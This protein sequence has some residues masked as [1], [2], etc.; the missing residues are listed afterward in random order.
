MILI[1]VS[2]FRAIARNLFSPAVFHTAR[3][4][5]GSLCSP[6]SPRGEGF[7]RRYSFSTYACIRSVVMGKKVF[8]YRSLYHSRLRDS[9]FPHMCRA[10]LRFPQLSFIPLEPYPARCARHFPHAGKAGDTRETCYPQTFG[11]R[12]H[13]YL[14]RSRHHNPE[15]RTLQPILFSPLVKDESCII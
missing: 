4:L 1:L 13:I 11:H 8:S 6:P 15:P 12:P 10:P 5:S 3:T 7:V 9:C 14:R 2:S